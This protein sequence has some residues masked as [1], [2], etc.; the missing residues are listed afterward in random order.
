MKEWQR[1]KAERKRRERGSFF[2][3]KGLKTVQQQIKDR[4]GEEEQRQRQTGEA[5]GGLKERRGVKE[6]RRQ[7]TTGGEEVK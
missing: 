2:A 5:G 1:R 4:R 7:W 6:D 3:A